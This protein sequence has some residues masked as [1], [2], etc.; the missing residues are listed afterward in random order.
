M[1]DLRLN[2]I[3]YSGNGTGVLMLNGVNYTGVPQ[4]TELTA[5]GE[6]C[7]FETDVVVPLKK[8]I[9]DID[10]SASSIKVT[11]QGPNFFNEDTELGRINDTTGQPQASSEVIRS[12]TFSPCIGGAT[13]FV[14]VGSG[15]NIRVYFYASDESFISVTGDI[16]NTSVTAPANAA[17]LKIRSTR[18]Y[19]AT[20]LGDVSINLTV[21]D[22]EYHP[23]VTPVSQTINL[24]TTRTGGFVTVS[25][26]G[27]CSY[28]DGAGNVT[29]LTAINPI[30]QVYGSNL[31]YCD[32]GDTEVIYRVNS[33]GIKPSSNLW[34]GLQMAIDILK[35]FTTSSGAADDYVTAVAGW[36]VSNKTVV[37]SIFEANTQYTVILAFENSSGGTVEANLKFV[38][39]DNTEDYFNVSGSANTKYTRAFVSASGKTITAIKGAYMDGTAKIYY[40]ESGLFEGVKT[41]DDFEP[42]NRYNS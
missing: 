28:D 15:L 41:V 12:K 13:Y 24:G 31:V 21:N 11:A 9:F 14:Y 30:M 10:S 16:N 40:D 4:Y 39:S 5:S 42:Y 6:F 23:Y 29:A 20:Y 33:G 34:G 36:G 32:T 37:D 17:Y 2:E 27:G 18:D 1:G 25:F 7:S 35:A 22:H 19:G 3:S 8:A 38:Y 26:D